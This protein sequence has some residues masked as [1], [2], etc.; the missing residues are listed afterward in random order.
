M[1]PVISAFKNAADGQRKAID[2]RGNQ[3]RFSSRFPFWIAANP[4]IECTFAD[5]NI[6]S[7]LSWLGS[8]RCR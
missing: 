5:E 6:R 7:Y 3:R 4:G 1:R 8:I 2:A